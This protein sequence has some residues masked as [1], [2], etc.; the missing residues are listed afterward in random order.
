MTSLRTRSVLGARQVLSAT[1]AEISEKS[2]QFGKWNLDG[3]PVEPREFEPV[4]PVLAEYGP[5]AEGCF[6]EN[7]VGIIYRAFLHNQRI[8]DGESAAHFVVR[9]GDYL[10]WSPRQSREFLEEPKPDVWTNSTDVSIV[11]AAYEH[12]GNDAF[13]RL[14]VTG[15][16]LS[17]SKRSSGC[18]GQGLRGD[19]PSLLFS[20]GQPGRVEHSPQPRSSYAPES[21]FTLDEEYIAGC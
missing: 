14:M 5:D 4:R 17:A 16:C 7:N 21:P 10:G 18:P 11:A 20:R 15:P 8:P 6:C 1:Q 19:S 12:W 3:R 2:V 9:I 13:R